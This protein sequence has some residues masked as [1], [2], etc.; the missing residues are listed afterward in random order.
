MKVLAVPDELRDEEVLACAVPAAGVAAGSALAQALHDHAGERLAYFKTP[1][2]IYFV[3]AL[4][5]TGTQK[6]QKHR[7]FPHGFSPEA[8][9]LHDLRD[10]KR[11]KK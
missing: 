11:W 3:D 4:P 9:G 5:V 10:R 2:W 1:G 7:I 6:V 8:P